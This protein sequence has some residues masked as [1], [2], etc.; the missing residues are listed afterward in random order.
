M[1]REQIQQTI[2]ATGIIPVIRATSAEAALQAAEAV[3]RGGIS[4][5]E[6]T[7]TVPNAIRVM[8]KVAEQLGGQVL[9]GAGTVL[10]P[11]TARA[12]ILAGAEFIVAPSLNLKTVEMA[13]RYSKVVLPGALTPTEVLAAW[14]A[15][16]DFVKIF[17]AGN[18]GGP[19]YIKALKAPFPQISLV[20]TG[21]VNLET[22][23]DFVLAGASALGVGGELVDAKALAAGHVEVIEENARKFLAC[24]RTAREAT[25][26]PH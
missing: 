18:V 24:V 9:L 7:M 21:G 15:G 22:A 14:E 25:A 12:A 11:E 16:A 6:I 10:D 5:V 8:E 17:P 19:K 23:A 13:H 4:V 3:S 20:P 1:T 2:V 26:S